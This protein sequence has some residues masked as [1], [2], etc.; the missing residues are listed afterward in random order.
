MRDANNMQRDSLPDSGVHLSDL[1]LEQMAEGELP[2]E[3]R[4]MATN[5]LASCA[6]CTTEL[7]GYR[8]LLVV[9]SELPRFAPS[10]AFADSV[11]ARTRL[12]PEPSAVTLWLKQFVPRTRRGWVL[13]GVAVV[14]PAMPFFAAAIWLLTH[15][16]LT[17]AALWQWTALQG[18][19]VTGSMWD[20]LLQAAASTGIDGLASGVIGT[21]GGVSQTAL[22]VLLIV[23]A[24]AIPLSAWAIVR[25]VRMPMKDTTT[26]AN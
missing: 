10:P 1:T 14:S 15:P 8:A 13:L 7:E 19:S 11:I 17:P 2:P 18:R 5:H 26:Y 12:T 3:E 21:A 16:L 20:V 4:D 6:R 9:L 24:L 25:L 22:T 23:L